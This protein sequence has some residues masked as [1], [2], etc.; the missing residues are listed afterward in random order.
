MKLIRLLAFALAL[1]VLSA[2]H[3]ETYSA[4]PD[5]GGLRLLELVCACSELTSFESVPDPVL[6]NEAVRVYRLMFPESASDDADVY[7]ALFLYGEY[8][9]EAG[10]EAAALMPMQLEVEET[11]G[12]P[13][14]ELKCTCTVR[15]DYGEG[16]EF[17]FMADI[18]IVRD[19]GSEFGW[20]VSRIFFPE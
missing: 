18:Y 5:E 11:M 16:F 13:D 2:A 7:S 17:A 15:F 3:G 4:D 9:A 19:A 12:L 10:A 14:D 20:R 6:A 1:F 8:R